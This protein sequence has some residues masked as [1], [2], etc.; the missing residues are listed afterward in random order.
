MDRGRILLYNRRMKK[1]CFRAVYHEEMDAADVPFRLHVLGYRMVRD[2][3]VDAQRGVAC[4]FL[5]HFHH[6]VD[7]QTIHGIQ[8]L[9]A[10]TCIFDKP[11]TPLYHGILPSW[12]HSWLRISGIDVPAMLARAGLR[13][14]V[15]YSV[16][17]ASFS[18]QWFD[19]IASVMNHALGADEDGARLL[20]QVWFERIAFLQ[21]M[22]GETGIPESV[23]LARQYIESRYREPLRLDD[24][25]H[26]VHLS[27]S[28]LCRLFRRYQGC[29]PVEYVIRCRLE[30]AHELLISTTLTVG[31]VALQSGFSDIYYFSRLFAHRYHMPPSQTRK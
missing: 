27:R 9:P 5:H 24:I 21:R 14:G 12:E 3:V 20:V 13:A 23:R 7:A 19:A 4:W 10:N 2:H 18:M 15:P 22:Q 11:M 28:Q 6:A 26:V 30:H 17:D 8:R 16:P 31:E 1:T 25:A 29:S